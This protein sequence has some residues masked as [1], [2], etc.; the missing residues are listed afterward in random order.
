MSCL[1]FA[2]SFCQFL[3]LFFRSL[4]KTT[5]ASTQRDNHGPFPIMVVIHVISVPSRLS[6]RLQ[7]EQAVFTGVLMAARMP[8][9]IISEIACVGRVAV[10]QESDKSTAIACGLFAGGFPLSPVLPT[11]LVASAFGTASD[12]VVC[13]PGDSYLTENLTALDD[14]AVMRDV[15]ARWAACTH[16][17]VMRVEINQGSDVVTPSWFPLQSGFDRCLW[18]ETVPG[19]RAAKSDHAPCNNAS[20]CGTVESCAVDT[21]VQV[22]CDDDVFSA[23]SGGIDNVLVQVIE[24]LDQAVEFVYISAFELRFGEFS[25]ISGAVLYLQSLIRALRRGVHVYIQTSA[26]NCGTRSPV[27]DTVWDALVSSFPKNLEVRV[28]FKRSCDTMKYSLVVPG[29][30]D[31]FSTVM[32]VVGVCGLLPVAYIENILSR[33][34]T[35]LHTRFVFSDR[36]LVLEGGNCSVKY[37]PANKRVQFFERAYVFALVSPGVINTMKA[38][39]HDS[40][41]IDCDSGLTTNK[42]TI[43]NA[44]YHMITNARKS[45]LLEHQYFYSEPRETSNRVADLLFQKIVQAF[46]EKRPFH[47]AIVTNSKFGDDSGISKRIQGM[48]Q[49]WCVSRLIRRVAAVVGAR[50]RRQYLTVLVPAKTSLLYVHTKCCI[51]DDAHV[52]VG[53]ANLMDRSVVDHIGHYELCWYKTNCNP[54]LI[55][56]IGATLACRVAGSELV[57]FSIPSSNYMCTVF[58]RET[59]CT[60]VLRNLGN[61]F[62]LTTARLTVT[63]MELVLCVPYTIV[64]MLS[65]LVNA[66]LGA[67]EYVAIAA[68]R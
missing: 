40:V 39:W 36:A 51:V 38:V 20:S 65:L 43:R 24:C 32:R 4:C 54:G 45:V 13:T 34:P 17:G 27:E 28:D 66:V 8:T 56:S 9:W 48:W 19:V 47:V 25:L 21:T 10:L 2:V 16:G 12:C 61:T 67:V 37:S 18:P 5:I 44:M 52:L 41:Q 6:S 35:G 53:S 58:G 68:F 60:Y 33:S 29:I 22:A 26:L 46:D 50:R 14:S 49:A 55:E 57:E 15:V 63:T 3:I 23:V 7:Y 59:I 64:F 1:Y 30:G 62:G 42:T 31:I 11:E